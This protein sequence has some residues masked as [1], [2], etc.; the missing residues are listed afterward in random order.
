MDRQRLPLLVL[1]AHQLLQRPAVD[2]FHHDEVA[3]AVLANI[4]DSDHVGVRQ[5]SRGVGLALETA[6]KALIVGQ[7]LVENL[8][9]H[10]A[11]EGEVL[12]AIDNRHTTA[13][14]AI[15]EAIAAVEDDWICCHAMIVKRTRPGRK[16]A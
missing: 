15:D 10:D 5:I 13:A 2:K 3:V 12:G 7:V 6:Q 16:R 11:A 8:D 14:D 9:R 1:Q 4:V